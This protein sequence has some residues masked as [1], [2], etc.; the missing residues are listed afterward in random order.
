LDRQTD[1]R[2]LVF[3]AR[4]SYLSIETRDLSLA[5]HWFQDKGS[6]I[7]AIQSV[8]DEACPLK[9]GVTRG[10]VHGTGYIVTPMGDGSRS[11]VT[12]IC[13]VDLKDSRRNLLEM[14]AKKLPSNLL[15]LRILLTQK[16][17]RPDPS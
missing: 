15:H 1:I 4:T 9:S 5:Y 17:F 2:H 7:I 6:Y 12:F 8:E 11:L 10:E 13:N 16:R 3:E 14:L